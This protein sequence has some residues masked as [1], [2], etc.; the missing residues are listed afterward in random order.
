MA[1]SPLAGHVAMAIVL[2]LVA[3]VASCVFQP[4]AQVALA[5]GVHIEE[6][7]SGA[8]V[9]YLD[10]NGN[11]V[12]VTT[13]GGSHH[14]GDRYTDS[15]GNTYRCI[16]P[17][18]MFVEGDYTQGDITTMLTQR[19][20]ERCAL[21]GYW[22][23]HNVDCDH[24]GVVEQ[25]LIWKILQQEGLVTDYLNNGTVDFAMRGYDTATAFRQFN[26]WFDANHTNFE[27]S[28]TLWTNGYMQKLA[29]FEATTVA[30]KANLKKVSSLESLTA[31]NSCYS[32]SGA[33]YSLYKDK[34]CTEAMGSDYDLITTESGVSNT[35][36]LP[37]GT[38]WVREEEAPSGFV[39]DTTPHKVV[40]EA[41]NNQITVSDEPVFE[42]PS[43]WANKYDINIE[44]AQGDGT[45]EGAQF[46]VRFYGG[47]YKKVSSIPS[48]PL[49]T[50]VFR[51]DA[52]GHIAVS[53]DALVRGDDLFYNRAGRVVLPLGTITIQETKAPT[54]Y[55]LEGQDSSSPAG[56]T[57]PVHLVQ[58]T[59]N[60]SYEAPS[61][62]EEVKRGGVKLGKVDVE[63]NGAHP[64]GDATLEGAVFA[65]TLTSEHPVMVDGIT[66]ATGD[67]V[68]RIVSD[69]NGK[70]ATGDHELPYGSYAIYEESAPLGYLTNTG[71]HGS[72]SIRSDG[73]VVDLGNSACA[74]QVIR[75][76][77]IVGK[78]S[79][80][81][82]QHLSQGEATLEGATLSVTLESAQPVVVDG[83]AHATGEVVCTLVT[84]ENGTASTA[85]HALPYGTYTVREVEAPAGYL[86]NDAWSLTFSVRDDGVMYDFSGETTSVDDQVMRGGFY[87]NKV[88]EAS[89]ER[90]SFAVFRITSMTT[91]ESHIAVADENGLLNTETYAHSTHTNINDAAVDDEGV[92][93]EEYIAP[94]AG[95]WFSG[96]TDLETT[97]DDNKGALPY[98]VYRIEELRSSANEGMKLVAF[99]VRIHADGYVPDMGTVDNKTEPQ[100][101]I[102]TTLTYQN[103]LHMAPAAELVV[104]TDTVTYENL[105]P[106]STYTMVG[107]LVYRPDGDPVLGE[108]GNPVQ[109][110]VD[111]VPTTSTG[112]V[113]LDFSVNTSELEGRDLVAIE[114]LQIDGDMVCSHA[115]LEDEGQTVSIPTIGTT[116]TDANSSHE[117]GSGELVTLVDTVEYH[118]ITPGKY[119]EVTGELMNKD[120]GEALCDVTGQPI[121]AT[122]VFLAE[123]GDG[124]TTVSFSFER[125]VAAGIETV[126]FETLRQSGVG[127]AVHA[128]LADEAQTVTVPDIRTQLTANDDTASMQAAGTIELTDTVSYVGLTA[129][130]TY[131]LTGTLMDQATGEALTDASGAPI[132]STTSFSP[133]KSSG[134][135]EITFAFDASLLGDRTL[136]A[137]ESLG[138]DGREVAVH[139]DLADEA[140]TVRFPSIGTTFAGHEDTHEVGPST[141]TTLIDV[142][143][144]QGLK[145]GDSYMLEGTLMSKDT[146][147]P[148]KDAQ[149]NAITTQ[150]ELVPP[151]SS[152]TADVSFMV[153]TNVL[154]GTDI[155]AFERLYA[156]NDEDLTVVATHEDLEDEGQTISVPS[157]RT[158]ATNAQ[159]G[160]HTIASQGK[161]KIRDKVA[162]TNLRPGKTYV[163][164]G[165]L[166][167]KSTG[168][169]VTNAGK[170]PVTTKKK[171]TPKKSSG[172]VE[173]E[174]DI[175]TSWVEGES[176]VVF[177][178]CQR[179]G[180]EVAA[181]ADL[182]DK[183]QTIAISQPTEDNSSQEN[184]S[185]GNGN[186]QTTPK[187]GDA[188]VSPLAMLAVG[189]L[190]LG[191]GV[192]RLAYVSMS[193]RH[194]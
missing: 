173:L 43:T 84:D 40:V 24:P 153:D 55:F 141:Q 164:I 75:G 190:A 143:A 42:T 12:G 15:S 10:A 115:D 182:N 95:I 170:K 76:G 6:T 161:V 19:A 80:E 51:S 86:L 38:Y 132:T 124:T 175:D 22:V 54:G 127:L 31:G 46:T 23:Q 146:G 136:V 177:E 17:H 71:Y 101:R 73:Q 139:A 137:F 8:W 79:R 130:S 188:T 125:P 44:Q 90:L 3:Q 16:E 105:E 121:R 96:R 181:H 62:G 166:M 148:L 126:A 64:Q 67:V 26:T 25:V 123:E 82:S 97:P 116:L 2:A 114:R 60:G 21:C 93:T 158:T 145:P 180:Y 168:K 61:L 65:I 138:H 128:D 20:I 87:I 45:L 129:G 91:G 68:K 135:A 59:G 83:T 179:G 70:A 53:A 156:T 108:D 171:F 63:S 144:Y 142:V 5:S 34:G 134:R 194:K 39:L 111:F 187:T 140:Q 28:A 33:R 74:D 191:G 189:F 119:Y 193:K 169:P 69:A 163:M 106:G 104:L 49:R 103:G 72:F 174:F 147:K 4:F 92:V 47:S 30:G 155:V 110:T 98:D 151:D 167:S 48:Q 35:V 57:A 7:G 81:T 133:K 102:G 56:Y 109:A 176:L 118:N 29:Q 131:E 32:L 149:G 18:I 9:E 58:V 159:D 89:M 184:P 1:V 185:S 172:S 162:Y 66:Y 52:Q 178:S 113:S 157:I 36:E 165:T 154:G 120:T 192:A 117:V 99:T 85:D 78:V 152:G 107:E 88:S 13:Q 122:S 14:Q 94:A 160:S 11:E 27:T 37:L 150:V 186:R 50:W 112:T 41:G 183:D 100:P 77:V